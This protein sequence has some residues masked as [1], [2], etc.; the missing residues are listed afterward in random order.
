VLDFVASID[1]MLAQFVRLLKP[2]GS[3]VITIPE[4]K[5]D[6][7]NSMEMK[8]IEQL[9]DLRGLKILRHQKLLG[10]VDS[11][12]KLTTYYRGLLLTLK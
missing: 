8:E 10:Y 6:K 1:T 7:L 12:T 4:T 11:E 9:V 5:N 2:N 3:I